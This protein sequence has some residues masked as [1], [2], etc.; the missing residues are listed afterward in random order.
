[1]GAK[2]KREKERIEAINKRKLEVIEA[3][4][5]MF[6]L[7]TIELTSMQDIADKAEV[8]VA[9]I[10]RYYKNKIDLVYAVAAN[11]IDQALDDYHV[12]LQGNGISK[13][14]QLIDYLLNQYAHKGSLLSF[15]EQFEVFLL[16]HKGE[17]VDVFKEVEKVEIKLLT[18]VLLEGMKDGSIR[19]DVD[20]TK[21]TVTI[22]NLYRMIG[23]KIAFQ[24]EMLSPELIAPL[25]QLE[26]YKDMMIKY[27]TSA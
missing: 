19:A 7:K 24:V 10:Y 16:T 21:T 22:V 14:E 5:F 3:A 27:L 1:M 11:Y 4:K 25:E 12:D 20:I 2:E 17:Q 6:A 15:V 8:G 9:S 13:V 23:Q 18:Q 26:I